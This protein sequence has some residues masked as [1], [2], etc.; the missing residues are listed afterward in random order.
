MHCIKQSAVFPNG[1]FCQYYNNEK[2]EFIFNANRH[3]RYHTCNFK[4]L[5]TVSVMS[6]T[7]TVYLIIA[8]GFRYLIFMTTN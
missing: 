8:D 1:F 4:I 2:K 6:F 5:C 7:L 3:F